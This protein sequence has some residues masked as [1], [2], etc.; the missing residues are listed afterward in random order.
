M[1]E[2][3]TIQDS[4]QPITRASPANHS[5]TNNNTLRENAKEWPPCSAHK[6]QHSNREKGWWTRNETFTLRSGARSLSTSDVS[7]DEVRQKYIHLEAGIRLRSP[8]IPPVNTV[9]RGGQIIVHSTC[10]HS[11]TWWSDHRAFHQST[12]YDMAVRSSC[13]PPV[14][15]VPHGGQITVYSTGQH[16]TS[17]WS[18]HRAFHQSKQ[19]HIPPNSDMDYGIFNVRT[20]VN[21]CDCTREVYGLLKR[22]C[23]ES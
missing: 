3:G 5:V 17:W 15:T 14:I 8:C 2:Q 21:A 11:T 1:V 16:S 12:Q 6:L 10:K 19:Y 7:C 13:I 23:T 4:W 20:D 18:D 9:P 22:V